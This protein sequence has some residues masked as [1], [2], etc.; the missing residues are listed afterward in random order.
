M[1]KFE[2]KNLGI[3]DFQI[4]KKKY[5]KKEKYVNGWCSEIAQQVKCFLTNADS[6]NSTSGIHK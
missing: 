1:P 3:N 2:G 5:N 6:A 4:I